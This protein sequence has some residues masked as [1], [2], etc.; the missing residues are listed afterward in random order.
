MHKIRTLFLSRNITRLTRLA[1]ISRIAARKRNQAWFFDIPRQEQCSDFMHN[2]SGRFFFF[3]Q[4]STTTAPT[5]NSAE[6]TMPQRFHK[7]RGPN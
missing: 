6:L 7:D 3:G 4:G 1:A 2:R 5:Y